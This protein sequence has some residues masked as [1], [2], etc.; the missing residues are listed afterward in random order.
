MTLEKILSPGT[1]V[2]VQSP[3]VLSPRFFSCLRGY[4]PGK[5]LILDN[6]RKDGTARA[7]EPGMSCIIR[8]LR[9]TQVFGFKTKVL[10]RTSLPAPLVFLSYPEE[11]ESLAVLKGKARQ[12]LFDT[13][14]SPHKL[15]GQVEDQPPGLILNLTE[16][17]CLVENEEP[18]DINSLLYLSFTLPESEPIQ[19]LSVEVKTCRS[20]AGRSHIVFNFLDANPAQRGKIKTYLRTLDE[21]NIKTA[22]HRTSSL[23]AFERHSDEDKATA[24]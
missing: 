8:L 13:V 21:L 14:F 2:L 4:Q 9:Q 10:F 23:E 17:G 5:Y 16:N 18:V 1:E 20:L 19:D 22:F 11:M 3:L 6:Q 24:S 15:H 12:V 7:L